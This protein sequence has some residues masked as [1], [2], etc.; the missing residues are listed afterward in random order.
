MNSHNPERA[1]LNRRRL[2]QS[3]ALAAA[4]I[5]TW[6]SLPQVSAQT[7][8]VTP[9]AESPLLTEMVAAGTIPALADRLPA[10]PC[11]IAPLSEV[12]TYGGT[13]RRA[14][15]VAEDTT[16]ILALSR[17][18]LVEWSVGTELVAT[19]ALAESWDLS[20][21]GLVYTFHLRA[22]T[23]WS[24][25]EPFTADDL[26]FWYESIAS[27][28][29]LTV[30]FPVWLQSNGE[31]CVIAKVDEVTVTF[32][33]AAP[34]SLLPRFLAFP[35][36]GTT[37]IVPKHYLSQFH[38]DI[39]GVDVV[40]KLVSDAGFQTWKEFFEAKN[41][42]WTNADRPV[43][44]AW[45]IAQ[46]VSG[47]TTRAVAER[48][49]F[50]WKVD[51]A[52]NQLPYIDS[53]VFDV[54]DKASIVLRAANGEIDMQ[55]KFLGFGDVPVLQGG[56][57]EKDFTV[58]QWQSDAPWIGMYMNQTHLDPT[59]RTLMQNIDFRAGLSHA[60]NRDEMNQLLYLGLG[61]TQHPCAVPGDPYYV[62]GYGY[63]FT[64]FNLDTANQL[65]DTAGV[66]KGSDGFRTRPDG[67]ELSLTILTFAYETG[68][69]ASDG[70][71][72]VKGYWEAV[73]VRTVVEIVD[74]PLWQER[75]RASEHDIAG[76]TTAGLL[77]DIDPLWY[78]PTSIQ[79]YWAPLF[80]INYAT[81]GESGEAAPEPISELQGLYQLMSVTIDEAERIALGQQILSIHDQNVWMIGTVTTP[82][83]P[84]VISNRLGNVLSEAVGSWRAGHEQISSFE[85]IY[86]K[87]L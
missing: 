87:S 57:E 75:V 86:F 12:G 64:E 27:N 68:V 46:A 72:L 54:L 59:M 42:T 82:F 23:K 70:Y 69:S 78:V 19:P 8:V 41:N 74:S 28:V 6:S 80:G 53:L 17:A 1:S 3:S 45:K 30:A 67:S 52:G 35:G 40:N 63:K 34:N 14:Q 58:A 16:G 22:G 37:L 71:E 60:I 13:I 50:Y 11:V 31:P 56:A 21:D 39:A 38:P 26:V 29:D 51:T 81:N 4:G 7:P 84:T 83:Q 62:E 47:G 79:T 66:P 73:G 77:W 65:L 48:N 15:Q 25:G 44:G 18:S 33:F 24:D 9:A 43:L 49:P 36:Q 2:V 5:A 61:G 32:T 85:Q 55:Y 10:N 20:E 76:Y